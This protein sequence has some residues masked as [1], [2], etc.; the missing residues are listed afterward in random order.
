MDSSELAKKMLEWE[1]KKRYL[2]AL[3]AEIEAEVLKIG[4]TQIVGKV[5]VTYSGG[6]ATY[7][8]ETP[9]R[10]ASIEVIEKHSLEYTVTDWDLVKQ[11]V[12]EVVAKFTTT[13]IDVAWN[14]VCKD[15]SIEPLVIS[16]TPATATIKLEK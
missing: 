6:R 16:R 14:L 4:K 7:D 9:A 10:E 1:E 2:D 5:R 8:Y 15:A 3:G 11:E 12:P 13:E